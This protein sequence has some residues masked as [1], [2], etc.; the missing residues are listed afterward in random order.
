MSQIA[1]KTD[2]YTVRAAAR[3]IRELDRVCFRIPFNNSITAEDD[4]HWTTAR[5]SLF[6][7]VE[8]AGYKLDSNSYRPTRVNSGYPDYKPVK[9]ANR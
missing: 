7:I 3:A 5:N 4:N 6:A 1:E 2:I 9:G 8:T